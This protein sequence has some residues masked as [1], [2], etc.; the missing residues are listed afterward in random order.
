VSEFGLILSGFYA[1]E[2][3]MERIKNE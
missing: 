3:R 1:L 2:L